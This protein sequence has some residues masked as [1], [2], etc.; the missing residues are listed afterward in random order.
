MKRNEIKANVITEWSHPNCKFRPG[1]KVR[2]TIPRFTLESSGTYSRNYINA[3]DQEG[4]IIAASATK[5]GL[6]R[7]I[8]Y[9]SVRLL[10]G[11]TAL[12]ST[13]RQYTRY[14]VEF[15]DGDVIGIH[16]HHL[17]AI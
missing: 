4:T 17:T 14:Y 10:G 2:V 12:W 13:D 16:S 6:M 3:N 7:G 5:D 15:S 1:Q 9:R 8:N 11:E